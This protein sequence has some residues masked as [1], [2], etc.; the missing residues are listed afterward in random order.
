MTDQSRQRSMP[1]MS[2]ASPA[3]AGQ[4]NRR[5]AI[6]RGLATAAV[7]GAP[8]IIARA[9]T[10]VTYGYTAV[11]DFATVFVAVE[12]GFFAK[13]DLEVEPK[14]IPLNPTILP[15]IQSGSLQMGGPTPPGYLQAVEGG[16]DHVVIGGG[17]VF[18]KAYTELGLVA[19]A[20]SN[21]RNAADCEGKKIG[22]PGLGALLHVTFRQWLKLNKVDYNK[23]N[24]VE[25]SFPQHADLIRGGSLDA[26]VSGG[27]FMA[28]IVESGAGY[29]AAYYTT[30]LPEGNPTILHTARRDW[31]EQNMG[32]VKAFR[33]GIIEA[34]G[35]MAKPANDAKVRDALG[36]YMKLPPAVAAKMQVSPP[37]P[38]VTAKQL[39]WWVGVM[40]DQGML[41]T[42]PALDKLILKA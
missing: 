17:G 33:E 19:R 26:V 38:V 42:E 9:A 23:V 22:V 14:F 31:A 39:Q 12:Q 28:R 40:R 35:F 5:Q 29:V 7:L 21:I 8:A 16:L 6:G 41:K 18:S 36:K 10:K 11:T 15:A 24:F 20:G 37:S 2:D 1:L 34:A 3:P 4:P 32:A 13:R 27:P 25:A 30:F